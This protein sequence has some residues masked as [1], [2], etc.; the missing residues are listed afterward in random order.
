M[1]N[2]LPEQRVDPEDELFNVLTYNGI[3]YH[4][5]EE[6]VRF[7][8]MD[9]G[10]E[11]ETVCRYASQTVVIY[12][13]YPFPVVNRARALERMDAANALLKRGSLFLCG[14]RIALRTSAEL[15]DAYSAQEAI[16]RALEYNAQ[17]M[18]YFWNSMASCADEIRVF[19]IQDTKNK[20]KTQ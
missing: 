2:F 1:N 19:D 12:G 5:D 13:V 6:G 8:L 10:R 15:F 16:T 17:A 4:R 7:A 18:T 11:W 9:A 14:D 20:A 3:A